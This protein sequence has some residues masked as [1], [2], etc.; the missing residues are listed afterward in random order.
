MFLRNSTY[1]C[2]LFATGIL[3]II[4][5]IALQL[6]RKPIVQD[7]PDTDVWCDDGQTY[8]STQ[9]PAILK[10]ETQRSFR[11]LNGVLLMSTCPALSGDK[12]VG[13]LSPPWP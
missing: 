7:A 11:S 2:I 9:S 1:V 13:H 5:V 3:I 10:S 8:V 4:S 6:L 12:L